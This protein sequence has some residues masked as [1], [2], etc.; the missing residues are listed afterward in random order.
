MKQ[1]DILHGFTVCS[2]KELPE[3]KAILYRMEYMKNGA[4]LIWLDNG[5]QNKLFSIAFKTIP[6]DDTG[7]FHILEHS[8]LGG[9]KKYPVKEPFLSMIKSSMSTFL[10]A[11]TFSDKT[12]YPVSSRNETDFM[13]LVSVYLDAVFCPT[14][15]DS[16]FTFYQ[17]GWH[18]ELEDANAQPI[19]KGVVYNEMKGVFSSV[20]ALAEQSMKRLLFPDN[21][22]RFEAG[23]DPERIPDLTYEDFIGTHKAFYHPSNAKIYLDGSVPIDRV[24]TL[25]DTY[26]SSY[27]RSDRRHDIPIQQPPASVSD[28]RYY[29]I[30]PEEDAEERVQ[31]SFGKIVCDYSERKKLL[32][33]SA[34]SSYLTGTNESPLKQAILRSGLAQDAYLDVADGIYQPYICLRIC[35]TEYDRKDEIKKTVI[36]T[37]DRILADGLDT[38]ELDAALSHMEFQLREFDEPKGLGRNIAVLN[39]WLYGGDPELYL[40]SS[41]LFEALRESLKTGYFEDLLAETL[42]DFDQMAELYLLPSAS[43]G[44]EDAEAEKARLAAAKA[45]WSDKELQAMIQMNREFAQWQ[46]APDT[47]E[48]INTLPRLTLDEI[49]E[50]SGLLTTEQTTVGTVPI[51]FHP[52]NKSDVVSFGLYFSLSDVPR[53][54]WGDLSFLTNIIGMLPTEN[55]SA[56]ELQREIK[57]YIGFIDYNI[58]AYPVPDR[59]ECCKPYFTVNCSVLRNRLDKALSLIT[60]ILSKTVYGGDESAD[61]MFDILLQCYESVRQDILGNGHTFA[62][63]RASSRVM[64]SG[65]FAEQTEGFTMYKWLERLAAEF[66]ERIP[67]LQ[68]YLGTVQKTIFAAKRMTVGITADRIPDEFAGLIKDL[69]KKGAVSAPDCLTVGIENEPSH[70][71]III[72][73]GVSYTA[74][75]NHLSRYGK[76]Y[77]GA[78][79]VL[80]SILSY[81][82]LWNEVRVKGGAYGCG[83]RTGVTGNIGFYSYRDPSPLS[84]ISV[85]READSFIRSYLKSGESIENYIISSI[86]AAEPLESLR[87][88]GQNADADAFCEITSEDRIRIRRE[89]LNT[90]GEDILSLC[91]LLGMMANDD[92]VCIVGNADSLRNCGNDWIETDL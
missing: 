65:C 72:P 51:L 68:A 4:E 78:L 80:S 45:K 87:E 90:T 53:E 42:S 81:E 77:S 92:A 44:D 31:M 83:C 18:Y 50:A 5:A 69:E 2:A 19:Y 39:S 48:A 82:Y 23:G 38:D 86:A 14:I 52:T 10:N 21:C 22:Y 24:L 40:N 29:A 28:V 55:H 15:Y 46:S 25:L 88:Q 58:V 9:S 16:P 30:G 43:K 6:T 60:E 66:D 89:M 33:L 54:H 59:P 20:D 13:N 71:I 57:R 35:N 49:A 85:F 47:M 36:Q 56:Y 1:G 75:T 17:E 37:V 26:L 91:G 27:E 64:A 7:V 34:L 61:M 79:R 11:M 74:S 62:M 12:V 84:S 32:A 70:E 63:K 41:A 73:S 76:R 3:Q 8:V 67:D